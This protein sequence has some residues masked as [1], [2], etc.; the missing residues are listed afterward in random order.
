MDVHT[1]NISGRKK[2]EMLLPSDNSIEILIVVFV[3]GGL[4]E[5]VANPEVD[6]LRE[7]A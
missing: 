3:E 5:M 4:G 7:T 2:Q 6:S 1:M